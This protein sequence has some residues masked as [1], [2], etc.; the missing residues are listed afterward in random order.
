MPKRSDIKSILIIGAGPIVIGQACEF[1]YSG[2]QACKALKEEGYKVLLINSN[3]ATIMTDPNVADITYIE[4]ITLEILSHIIEKERPD[5][6]LSTVGGQ[7]ALNM[8]M[9]LAKTGI[10][11]KFNVEL[12]GANVDAIEK[13]ENRQLFKSVIK[14]LGLA[15]PK[16]TIVKSM[17]E[18]KACLKKFKFP[19][20]V[21]PS[22]TLGGT[23]GGIAYSKEEFLEIAKNGLN[24]SPTGEILI[25]ESVIGWKEY[26][27]EVMR[28]KA[29]NCII[30]CSIEN[31][32]P[33][34]THTGDSIT[35]APALTLTDKEYQKMR[36]AAIAILRAI[37]ID[38]GGSN[39]QF[40]VNP[41][42]GTMFVIEMNP[43]VSRSSALASKATGFPIAKVAAKLAVGL[44]LDEIINDCTKNTSAAFEPVIDYIVTKIPRFSFEKFEDAKKELSISMKSVGEVMAIGR[45]FPESI[46]KALRSLE[47]GLT[48]FDETPFI[49]KS[50]LEIKQAL[51]QSLPSRLLII[52]DALRAGFSTNE[53]NQLTRYDKWFINQI[54]LIVEEERYIKKNGLPKEK[55]VIHHLKQLGFSDARLAYLCSLSNEDIM[56]LRHSLDVRPVYKSVDTCAAEFASK[57]SY[58]YS[59][60]EGDGLNKAECE[61]IPSNK[62][63]VI[64]LGSGPNRIGQGIE[65][66][67]ACV[68]AAQSLKD[69]GI[70]AIMI[71]C[72]PETVSTDYDICDKLYFEPVTFEDI[73]EIIDLEMTKGELLGVNVQFGG[74][75]PLKLAQY[76]T[77]NSIPILGTS[78][79]S[80]NCTENRKQ[81]QQLL[82]E[83]K[84]KYPKN[85]TCN[86]IKE[87]KEVANIL[88]YPVI[89]RPSYV[90]SGTGMEIFEDAKSLILYTQTNSNVFEN[91]PILI[92]VFLTEA[93]EVD[94]DAV[95]DCTDVYIAGIMQHVE[96]AGIHSGDSACSIPPYS[97]NSK[98][99]EEIK[100]QTRILANE[101]GI[102]GF[103]N[104]QFA[105]K[106]NQIYIL[107]VNPRASR[108]VPIVAKATGMH[109]AKVANLLMIGKTLKELQLVDLKYETLLQNLISVKMPVF[110][111]KRFPESKIFLGPE[112]KSTG[113]VM[114][115]DKQFDSAYAKALIA[116]GNTI[117]TSGT[118]LISALDANCSKLLQPINN[119]HNLGFRI[120]ILNNRDDETK[121]LGAKLIQI[122]DAIDNYLKLFT[123]EEVRLVIST[124]NSKNSHLNDFTLRKAA[125]LNN[126]LC[127]MTV[128]GTIALI[129]AIVRLKCYKDFEVYPLQVI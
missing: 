75:T 62:K 16:N 85:Y 74:Q 66:D 59:S 20:I 1:D 68:H 121:I 114:C 55:S 4:P 106:E 21:R 69:I 98:I 29:D 38:S 107:E 56:H 102:I 52:A 112:M 81:F 33:M 64:I 47:I 82:Q 39:V 23:G 40:A 129:R 117:P 101:L 78:T 7:T 42:D 91:G 94:V 108:T 105:I 22:F 124:N 53:I 65:F 110:P 80:I 97:L 58:F 79:T 6:I 48:G 118:I 31:I 61:S 93:I 43:R 45:S 95:S 19:L 35:V 103:I 111:F 30:V 11:Q 122:D 9:Q 109:I 73:L 71:N 2:T 87:V 17:K 116:C 34:G 77:N 76:L 50:H 3:P 128:P 84:L 41:E 44:T 127:V 63:K 90:L 123:D 8:A 104:I 89:V 88:H 36:N 25:D 100:L 92:D 83:L 70:E 28:D 24:V 60:Y 51:R 125:L 113:E 96:E 119:L 54:R 12:I 32:D 14:D 13:A 99:I 72:N 120:L 57:V 37:G 27:L 49:N 126:I 5:A 86:N 46:Q 10:L 67:Y 15:C 115:R 18:A 26:E